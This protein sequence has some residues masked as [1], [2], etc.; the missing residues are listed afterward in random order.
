MPSDMTEDEMLDLALRL[1]KQE[2]NSAN[3]REQ[4]EDDNV[5]KAIAESLQVRSSVLDQ[6]QTSRDSPCQIIR[7]SSDHGAA[8]WCSG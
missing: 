4:V 2:A 8:G 1:S 7:R 3:Q 6:D 5:R